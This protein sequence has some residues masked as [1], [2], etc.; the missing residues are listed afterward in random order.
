MKDRGGQLCRA[1]S[2]RH[3]VCGGS[4]AFVGHAKDSHAGGKGKC[5]VVG[6]KCRKFKPGQCRAFSAYGSKVCYHHGAV[7]LIG[8]ASPGWRHGKYAT[9][10]PGRM[11]DAYQAAREDPALLSLRE[12]IAFIDARLAELVKQLESGESAGAWSGVQHW[13]E[14]LREAMGTGSKTDM[15]E[16]LDRMDKLINHGIRA[17][18]V[19]KDIGRTLDRRR[20]LVESERRRLVEAGLLIDVATAE[21]MAL[22]LTEAVKRHVHDRQVLLAILAEFRALSNA[23]PDRSRLEASGPG[24]RRGRGGDVRLA[25]AGTT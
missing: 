1:R 9:V 17:Q 10:L 14:R 11:V 8:P 19:H 23:E 6:C 16:S 4:S 15:I 25:I 12:E 21:L 20:R 13:F 18:W 7:A 2:K 5:T 3:C 24:F 22:H